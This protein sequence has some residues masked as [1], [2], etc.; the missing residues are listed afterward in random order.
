MDDIFVN[1]CKCLISM[2]IYLTKIVIRISKEKPIA[3]T[4]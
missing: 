2:H 3:Y 4:E 1:E